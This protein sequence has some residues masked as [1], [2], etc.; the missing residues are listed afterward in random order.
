MGGKFLGWLE[1]N[2]DAVPES[3]VVNSLRVHY[4][5]WDGAKAAIDRV[6]QDGTRASFDPDTGFIHFPGGAKKFTI[7][8]DPMSQQ[9]WSLTNFMPQRHHKDGRHCQSGNAES[10][11]NTLALI[12]SPDLRDW[13]V[14]F[15]VLY[16]SDATKYGF[17][18]ADWHFNGTDIAAVFAHRLR[19]WRR[20]RQHHT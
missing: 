10:T 18:Y 17:Q 8:I 1:G 3:N 15:I 16:Q 7:R 4:H 14:R 9:F 19:R 5:G 11:R 2:A 13:Q 12:S 20:G 6:S